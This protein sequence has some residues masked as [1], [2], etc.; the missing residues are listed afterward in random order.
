VVRQSNIGKILLDLLG[1]PLALQPS[2]LDPLYH[3]EVV[4]APIE[5]LLNQVV[6]ID[7][8][9]L[10]LKIGFF[11]A[12]LEAFETVY[13]ELDIGAFG[14]NTFEDA[15]SCEYFLGERIAFV[16]LR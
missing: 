1:A 2:T 7:L 6:Y 16:H 11:I 14:A 5:G 12:D 3:L 10:A 15:F 9:A 4:V 8:H 13:I